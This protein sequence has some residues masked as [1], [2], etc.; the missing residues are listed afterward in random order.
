M[1]EVEVQELLAPLII[2]ADQRLSEESCE[3]EDNKAAD[4][5]KAKL[6]YYAQRL[7]P[8]ARQLEAFTGKS[9]QRTYARNKAR[10]I[11][12]EPG[13]IEF[14]YATLNMSEEEIAYTY[15]HE[16][17]H[18]DLGHLYNEYTSERMNITNDEAEHSADFWAGIFLG[19]H[20]YDFQKFLESKLKMPD[21]NTKHGSRIERAK[22]ITKGYLFGKEMSKG[23]MELG[24]APAY[25]AYRR[26][27]GRSPWHHEGPSAY[28]PAALSR[29]RN[30]SK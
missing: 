28:S 26:S 6:D 5:V 25:E 2:P 17:G 19:F 20:D 23:T 12:K 30:V 1:F 18:H 11:A 8:I 29:L 10:A 9:F 24:F 15:A 14:D 22:I 7:V 13:I 3:D 21:R 4:L 16:Y 27:T